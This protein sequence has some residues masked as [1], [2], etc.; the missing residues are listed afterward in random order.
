MNLTDLIGRLHPLL[1]HLPIGILL[2]AGLFQ[3]LTRKEK[4]AFL[5]PAIGIAL[6]W[7]MLSAVASCISGYLLSGTG[8]Y[9]DE[10]ASTHKW[11]GFAVA[12]VSL[13][14][15]LFHR[16]ENGFEKWVIPIMVL[17]I[18]VTGHLG[19]SLTHGSDYLVKGFSK[20][21]DKAQKEIK[22]VPDVQEAQVYA[23]IIQPIFESRC[24]TCHN[25][26]KKKGGLRLD[27]SSFILKGGKD[28]K[29]IKPG[30]ADESDMIKRLL[31]PRKDEDHM[32][33]K[34]K[35][36]LKENEIALI[37]WWIAT[38]ASFDKKTKELE[39]T[40]KIK[41]VLLALQK[42]APKKTLPDVPAEPVAA[43]DEKIIQQLKKSGIVVIPVSRS[44]NYLSVNFVTV[45]PV[46]DKEISLLLSI[47]KQ[48]IWLNLGRKKIKDDVMPTIGQLTNLTRLQL[49]STLITDIGIRSL[50]TLNNLQYLNLVGTKVTAQGIMQLKSVPGLQTIYLYKTFITAAD[51]PALKNSFPKITLDSGGYKVQ[52]L[53]TDTMIVKPPVKKN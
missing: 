21:E 52:F 25:K 15:Y 10:L 1:V 18:I 19:G 43:A 14:A 26:S 49:D 38:G 37:H 20:Q 12:F 2:L 47:K 39:Q 32:P 27:D 51:W 23:D 42:E 45:E 40:E 35:P 29:V 34:E 33:P 22:P 6:F 41:P 16:W 28:G 30:N 48:L 11:F 3:L 31:L 7:G 44:S 53:E 46:T 9:D 13:I 5:Q 24:Y 4:Y 17:L 8:D 50:Q 36:Q